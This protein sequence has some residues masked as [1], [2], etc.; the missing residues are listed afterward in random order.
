MSSFKYIIR[1]YLLFVKFFLD[2]LQS[3]IYF[4]NSKVYNNDNRG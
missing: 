4:T 2:I 1:L 3:L